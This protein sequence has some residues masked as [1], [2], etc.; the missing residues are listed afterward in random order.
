MNKLEKQLNNLPK[1]RLSRSRSLRLRGL[2]YKE[3]IKQYRERLFGQ[4]ELIWRHLVPVGVTVVI[5]A[6]VVVIPSYSYAS[7][8]VTRGHWLYPVKETIEKMEVSLANSEEEKTKVYNKLVDRRLAEA[9]VISHTQGNKNGALTA[10]VN[11]AVSFSAAADYSAQQ[12]KKGVT[13]ETKEKREKQV[14]VLIDIAQSVGVG[15]PE[16]TVDSIALAL[17][18]MKTKKT[19]AQVKPKE[20]FPIAEEAATTSGKVEKTE[21][22]TSTTGSVKLTPASRAKPRAFGQVKNFKAEE[23]KKK[24]EELKN[25][26]NK[27]KKDFVEEEY[28]EDEVE[29]LVG[30]LND[31]IDKAKDSAEKKNYGNLP[32]IF[33]SAEALSDNAKYFMRQDNDNDEK[34]NKNEEADDK[35]GKRNKKNR[36][37]F[38]R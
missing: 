7:G 27:L 35:K 19:R 6:L 22:D 33:H 9:K 14:D 10:T 18:K 15:A 2:I 11:A 13:A 34:N 1:A 25:K 21:S 26:V 31:K 37:N 32:G 4:R 5:L 20:T 3:M 28:D 16:Q 8:Q 24:I 12:V 38:F 30:R 29:V 36:F 17:D 23:V